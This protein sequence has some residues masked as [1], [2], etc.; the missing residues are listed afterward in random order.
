VKK[1]LN[2]PWFW[3][4]VALIAVDALFRFTTLMKKIPDVPEAVAT[5]DRFELIDQNGDPF[6]HAD[7]AGKV[8][9]V[10]F[11]FSSCPMSC[12]TLMARMHTLQETMAVQGPYEKIGYDL[13]LMAIT[14]DPDVDTPEVLRETMVK[15]DL[16]PDRWTLL[17]G[18]REA[19]HS[20]V[21][22]G[23]KTA[24]GAKTEIEPGV[25]D[26]AHSGK[27]AMLDEKG[28]VRGFYSIDDEGLDQAF[29]LGVRTLRQHRIDKAKAERSGCS[30]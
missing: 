18:D 29:W 26:I 13:K 5:I 27:L 14:V 20:L 2:S 1:L 15:Y 12:P 25:F 6:T 17:T 10:G 4:I 19:V 30:R 21:Q 8:H 3:G 7:L 24:M 23:F 28:A 16:D 11:F 22:T 9:I